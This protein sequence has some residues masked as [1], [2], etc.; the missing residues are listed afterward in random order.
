MQL[1]VLAISAA[2]QAAAPRSIE[3]VAGDLYRVHAGGNYHSALLVTA[4]GIIAIDP[5][6]REAALWLK[7]EIKARFDL[8]VKYLIYSH[9]D[10]DH[11]IGG[12]VFEGA[13]VI[14]H[15]KT[16]ENLIRD[17]TPTALPDITFS[18]QM[19][20]EFGGS[21]V[22]LI[23]LGIGHGDNLIAIH[24][25]HERAVLCADIVFVRRLAHTAL[26]QAAD[27]PQIYIPG[28][29]DSLHILESIDY[30]ILLTAHGDA[31]TKA[32][33]IEF[34]QYFEALYEAVVDAQRRGLSLEEAKESIELDQFR[35]LRMYDEWFE[36]NVE[37]M[38][39]LVDDL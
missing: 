5:M 35:H 19:S 39:K 33:G 22:N 36:L 10:E 29:I 34:R 4:E 27:E 24:F 32:D 12:E 1:L 17:N 16:K 3:H 23:Y 31:G 2:T 25:P 14:A 6:S 13:T 7:E 37:G 38:Y 20:L 8:P 21:K 26:G 30:D 15:K 28:W 11:S 18:D 9:S